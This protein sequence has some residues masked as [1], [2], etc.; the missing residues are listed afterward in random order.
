MGASRL[1]SEARDVNRW[2]LR[3]RLIDRLNSIRGRA[4]RQA[5]RK[6]TLPAPPRARG[7]V[8]T[9]RQRVLL[10]ALGARVSNPATPFCPPPAGPLTRPCRLSRK[11]GA[12]L[13]RHSARRVA[14]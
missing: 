14:S 9:Q 5:R 13:Q 1:R 6:R 4:E 2:V 7:G 10:S 3:P 11:A 8:R 12:Y